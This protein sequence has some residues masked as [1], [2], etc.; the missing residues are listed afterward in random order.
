MAQ[1]EFHMLGFLLFIQIID[2]DCSDLL[3][4]D[5][6]WFWH[7]SK[8]ISKFTTFYKD[9]SGSPAIDRHFL[10]FRQLKDDVEASGS[11][12]DLSV[13]PSLQTLDL[14][15]N[16]LNGT[17]DRSIGQLHK[18][19]VFS[20]AFN[21]LNGTSS[22]RS[23]LLQSLNSD[24]VPPFQLD[25]IKFSSCKLGPRFPKWLQT[26]KKFYKLDIS[27]A[28]I[29]GNIP[30]WF[31]DL[32]PGLDYL[33]VSHNQLNGFLPDLSLKFHGSGI[34]LSNNLLT[35]PIP[36][37][38]SNVSSLNLSKNKF[39]GSLAFLCAI[40]GEFFTYLDLSNNHR[41]S[42]HIPVLAGAVEEGQRQNPLNLNLPNGVLGWG[43][44]H[45]SKAL[46]L[47]HILEIL[48][49]ICGVPLTKK[50]PGEEKPAESPNAA[51]PKDKSIQ[52]DADRSITQGF[53]ASM[54]LGFFFGF[55]GVS[56]TTLFNSQSRHAYFKF[57]NHIIDWIYVTTSL[58]WAGLQRRL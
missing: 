30:S 29:V 12:P 37:V 40:S 48:N 20:C 28:G 17:I 21:L 44:A 56:G 9:L 39:G 25:V 46:M 1:Y 10:S 35:G 16:Q 55:W 38:P 7:L 32:S 57:L 27:S 2:K 42:F 3:Q 11:F 8:E 47:L 15:N 45:N 58:N 18:L 14:E 31:W 50:C 43:P 51:H 52:E 24:W 4:I 34:D 6:V 41:E 53:Y 19:R 26:R 13:F 36:L 49:L 22:D 54:G 5:N 33:N 23:T